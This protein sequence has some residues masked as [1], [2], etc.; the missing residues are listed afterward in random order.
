V[1]KIPLKISLDEQFNKNSIF[2]NYQAAPITDKPIHKAIPV[3]AQ[4]KG[5][6]LV[7]A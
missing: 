3:L 5:E 1:I 4:K 7:K 6:I 2:W